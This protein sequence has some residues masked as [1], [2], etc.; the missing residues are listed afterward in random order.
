M[1]EIVKSGFAKRMKKEYK[2]LPMISIIT[3]SFNQ[4]NFLEETI[5]SVLEQNYPNL[6]YIVM[7]GGSK[8]NTLGI[9]KKHQKEIIWESAPDRGQAHAINKGV[10]LAKGEIIAYLNSDDILLKDS[11]NIV[12]DLFS[13]KPEIQW[14]VGRCRIVD[15]NG[16]EIRKGITLYKNLLLNT[17]SHKA[18]LI[19]DYISQPSVFWRRSLAQ[20][21]GVFDES[22][23]YAMDYDYWLKLWKISPPC[24]IEEQLAGFRI[25]Q[26]SKTIT[27]SA[28]K[29]WLKEDDKVME[30]H[31]HPGFYLFLHLAHRFLMS[32]AY[33][34]INK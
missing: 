8:D 25:H 23:Y 19:T 22:L 27:G 7:D 16:N 29:A 24:F 34:L 2:T 4:G 13:R 6:E 15:D 11:L 33:L 10:R 5:C 9:L 28:S 32:Q 12:A 17:K 3:P 20:K 21:V 18:L 14:L 26:D 1:N 30:R 31:A